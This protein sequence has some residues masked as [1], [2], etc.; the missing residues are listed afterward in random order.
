[1]SSGKWYI[2]GGDELEA[3]HTRARTVLREINTL[4]N[5]DVPRTTELLAGILAEGSHVPEWWSPMTVEY[6][7]NTSFGEKC[8]I[9]TGMTIIDCAPVTVGARTLFGP[10]CELIT[11]GHP[12][13]DLEMRRSGWEIAEPITIGDDC[14]FGSRVSVLPG[15]SIGD[16]CVIAAGTVV[17]RDI[18]ADS[19]VMGVPG[20][21]VRTL[22]DAS[23][24]LE[25]DDIEL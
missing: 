9:N 21:V 15:V 12:V 5:L 11:V 19:L 13:Q 1:M 14:W 8:F 17:T 25:R 10:N 4:G 24:P 16:R 2:P 3:I 22:N 18:P 6:G 23:S 7:A 20:R